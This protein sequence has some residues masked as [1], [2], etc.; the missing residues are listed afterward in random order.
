MTGDQ[1]SFFGDPVPVKKESEKPVELPIHVRLKNALDKNYGRRLYSI[2]KCVT[3]P[4]SNYDLNTIKLFCD[5]HPESAKHWT[6]VLEK[7]YGK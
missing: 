3:P 5:N 2:W 7:K 1:L 4:S 6:E